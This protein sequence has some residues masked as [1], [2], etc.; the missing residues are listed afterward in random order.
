MP[1][2]NRQF[3]LTVKDLE[4]IESALRTAKRALNEARLQEGDKVE[5]T[6]K[7]IHELLG[8]LHNQKTFYRPSAKVYV[9][10]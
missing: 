5:G 8:R 7:D 2:P 10:G 1:R 4:L 3:D 6:V 9:S